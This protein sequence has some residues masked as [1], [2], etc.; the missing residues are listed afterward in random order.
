MPVN[1]TSENEANENAGLAGE[2]GGMTK[3]KAEYP[4]HCYGCG[5]MFYFGD[6]TATGRVSMIMAGAQLAYQLGICRLPAVQST[7]GPQVSKEI[8]KRTLLRSA[9]TLQPSRHGNIRNA[10]Y[11]ITSAPIRN[12][13]R[14]CTIFILRDKGGQNSTGTIANGAA[15]G[16]YR[17]Q[18]EAVVC[19][20]QSTA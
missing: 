3:Q 4:G 17:P 9:S 15:S 16:W 5:G 18:D 6:Y 12:W 7:A 11:Q 10:F 1:S 8:T 2:E 20:S 14:R 19:S 13:S